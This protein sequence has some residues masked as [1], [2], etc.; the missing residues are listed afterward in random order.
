MYGRYRL[1]QKLM[2]AFKTIYNWLHA[3]LIELDISVL[4]RKG[5][6]RHPKESPET[7]RIGKSITKRPKERLLKPLLQIGEKSSSAILW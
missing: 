4:R 7:F 3:G 5:K 2:V 6:T 1:E